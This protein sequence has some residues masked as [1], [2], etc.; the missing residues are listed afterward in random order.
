[1]KNG[2]KEFPVENPVELFDRREFRFKLWAFALALSL[3]LLVLP[4][5]THAGGDHG[6]RST[7]AGGPVPGSAED[8]AY[9][10]FMHRLN[11]VF[12]LLLGVVA[13][14]EGRSIKGGGFLRWGWPILFFLS[15]GYLLVQSDQDGWPIGGKTFIESMQDPMIFQHKIAA[16]ILLFLGLSELLLRSPW[17]YPF[18]E[19]VF[20]GLTVSAG[21]MLFFHGG[22]HMPKIHVQHLFMGG[23]ALAIGIARVSSKKFKAVELLWPLL[24][25]LMALELL[26]YRE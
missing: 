23:T 3:I 24:I 25:L 18:L 16:S 15:G 11:G 14:L 1:V 19:W 26:F 17:R 22:R 5:S 12:V 2:R 4:L 21:L 10:E 20:P 6:S 13:L 7:R 8:I 9:S